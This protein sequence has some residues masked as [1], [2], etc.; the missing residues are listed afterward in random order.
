[1]KYLALIF[2]LLWMPGTSFPQVATV[3]VTAKTAAIR[4]RPSEKSK[5][6][7]TAKLDERFPLARRTGEKEWYMVT[8]KGGRKVGWIHMLH[9]AIIDEGGTKLSVADWY[10][11]V[12]RDVLTKTG[13][14]RAGDYTEDNMNITAYVNPGRTTRIGGYVK[15]W[16]REQPWS[17]DVAA[18]EFDHRLI[19]YEANCKLRTQ[20]LVAHYDYE[21]DGSAHRKP[22]TSHAFEDVVPDSVGERLLNWACRPSQPVH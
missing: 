17:K 21:K 16:V 2:L 1:M 20:R 15:Y 6:L 7:K 12:E 19:L 11:L 18:A 8:L 5:L 10:F 9:I 13:W 14:E 22:A 3:V 4:L